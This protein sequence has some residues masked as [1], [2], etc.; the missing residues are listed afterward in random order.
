MDTTRLAD[1]HT[2]RESRWRVLVR[3]IFLLLLAAASVVLSVLAA[4]ALAERARAPSSGKKPPPPPPLPSGPD[5]GVIG[6]ATD[7]LRDTDPVLTVVLL[8]LAAVVSGLVV[9]FVLQPLFPGLSRLVFGQKDPDNDEQVYIPQKPSA[10][11][12]PTE[13]ERLEPSAHL[14]PA[15][16]TSFGQGAPGAER[17]SIARAKNAAL[18][19]WDSGALGF[20]RQEAHEYLLSPI[21]VDLNPKDYFP[22]TE[23]FADW[24]YSLGQ[25][26]PGV[27]RALNEVFAAYVKSL[28][29]IPS[30]ESLVPDFD[31]RN[32]VL[33][34]LIAYLK[35]TDAKLTKDTFSPSTWDVLR[36]VTWGDVGTSHLALEPP[37]RNLLAR[38][39]KK[40]KKKKKGDGAKDEEPPSP[41]R[42]KEPSRF[43]RFAPPSELEG[44]LASFKKA[45]PYMNV[46]EMDSEGP[47]FPEDLRNG[48]FLT[49]PMRGHLCVTRM[50]LFF[51]KELTKLW[52][53]IGARQGQQRLQ[54]LAK[55][56]ADHEG[57][58]EE[59]LPRLTASVAAASIKAA[60]KA[61]DDARAQRAKPP[62]WSVRPILPIPPAWRSGKP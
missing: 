48:T 22:L 34:E 9:T 1:E 18:V 13:L 55:Y 59:G 45:R 16:A 8:L 6:Q 44:L 47:S 36:A 61:E 40:T 58:L 27:Y 31:E 51:E 26:K 21:G 32:D 46:A 5:K 25:R 37:P 49:D 3:Y 60:K 29:D 41:P 4:M 39:M 2:R 53:Q 24:L 52:D 28:R 11:P 19:L 43:D 62:T 14:A 23:R 20:T 17:P 7:R 57:P 50:I 30:L 10:P 42:Y 38:M 54:V 15:L 33:R 56:L 12:L 35:D